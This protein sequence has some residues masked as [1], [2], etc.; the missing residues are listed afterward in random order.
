MIGS[1]AVRVTANRAWSAL[2][3]VNEIKRGVQLRNQTCVCLVS[4]PG[5]EK[6][7]QALGLFG[8]RVGPSTMAYRKARTRNAW[9]SDPNENENEN[10][11]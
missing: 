9:W 2:D 1:L 8:E 4:Y 6:S 3:H 5:S 7:T 10:S 11:Q